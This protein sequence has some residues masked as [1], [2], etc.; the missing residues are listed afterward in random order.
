MVLSNRVTFWDGEMNVSIE[1][2]S[3]KTVSK[4]MVLYVEDSLSE[5]V[6]VGLNLF[7]YFKE[8]GLK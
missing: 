7:D 3:N 4:W 6:T 2:V 5:M 1:M 8:G